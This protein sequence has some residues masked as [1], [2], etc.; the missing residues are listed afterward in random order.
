MSLRPYW[1]AFGSR[2]AISLPEQVWQPCNVDGDRLGQ[3]A[4]NRFNV[5]SEFS[6]I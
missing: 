6:M 2:F 1:T 4:H 3:L 5:F